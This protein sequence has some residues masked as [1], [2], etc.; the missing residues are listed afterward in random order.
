MDSPYRIIENP[1]PLP[2]PPLPLSPC[3][4][5]GSSGAREASSTVMREEAHRVHEICYSLL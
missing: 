1:H 3:T 2:S 4:V 5:E